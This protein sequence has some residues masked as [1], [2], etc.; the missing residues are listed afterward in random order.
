MKNWMKNNENY[1]IKSI[2]L[3]IILKVKEAYNVKHIYT[4]LI[5]R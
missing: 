2:N 5:E 3:D 1:K 4:Y